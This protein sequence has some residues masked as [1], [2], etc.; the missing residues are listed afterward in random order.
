MADNGF[1]NGSE[2]LSYFLFIIPT[3]LNR[4]TIWPLQLLSIYQVS[5]YLYLL[6]VFMETQILLV[7]Y[8]L[9]IIY[10]WICALG[11]CYLQPSTV[12]EHMLVCLLSANPQLFSFTLKRNFL[13]FPSDL[14]CNTDVDASVC[15]RICKD[16]KFVWVGVALFVPR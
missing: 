13:C 9:K 3:M 2:N 16:N 8:Q 10:S 1:I 4:V 6:C 7:C 5:K 15:W 14:A 11:S 12:N